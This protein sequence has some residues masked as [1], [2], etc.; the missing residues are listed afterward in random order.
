MPARAIEAQ[1]MRGLAIEP[2][3]YRS[4]LVAEHVLTVVAS[5]EQFIGSVLL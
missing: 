3:T 2:G 5:S 4:T 1:S